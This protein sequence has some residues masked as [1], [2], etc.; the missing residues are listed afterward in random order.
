ME[1]VNSI[2][3]IIKSWLSIF[4]KKKERENMEFEIKNTE[5]VKK[6]EEKRQEV[7]LRDKLE[8]TVSVIKNGDENQKKLALDELRRRIAR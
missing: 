7:V 3:A 2:L 4:V 5:E 6:V 8:E 1:F